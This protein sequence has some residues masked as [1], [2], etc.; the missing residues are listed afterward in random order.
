MANAQRLRRVADQIQRELAAIISGE[1]KDPRV[2]LITLTD[3]EVSS[4][5]A[6]AKVFYTT[7]V[8]GE[9]R[10]EA[11][12]ALRRAAGFM[13]TQLGKRIKL[14]ATPELQF[15]YDHSIERGFALDRLI[16][17]AVGATKSE[18]GGAGHARGRRRLPR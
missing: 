6:H 18:K 15:E 7:L 13:R 2:A 12:Q 14:H 9:S 17:E 8:E 1:L 11:A 4:D 5:L 3:V 10:E 16:D